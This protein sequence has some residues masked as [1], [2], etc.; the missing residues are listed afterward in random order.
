MCKMLYI[1]MLVIAVGAA[2]V[3]RLAFLVHSHA[4]HWTEPGSNPTARDVGAAMRK[5]TGA[6][7]E[8]V[9]PWVLD[10]HA[11][12]VAHGGSRWI[13]GRCERPAVSDSEAIDFAHNDAARQLYPIVRTRLNG[14]P[15]DRRWLAAQIEAQARAGRLDRDVCLERFDRPYGTIYCAS[16]LVDTSA[17][18]MEPVVR[19]V[20]AGLGAR[21]R[22]AGLRVALA[23]IVLI[24]TWVFYAVSNSM[25][26]G[27]VTTRLRLIAAAVTV[28]VLLLA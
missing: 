19:D 14:W 1:P 5:I 18:A 13:V 9:K 10:E 16:V 7:P 27:Y 22:R 26:R 11:F 23:G 24:V 25:T 15:S 6:S 21:H 2:V 8:S 12:R 17:S 28:G 4:G 20:R 3:V